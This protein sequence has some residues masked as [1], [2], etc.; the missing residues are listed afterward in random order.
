[1]TSSDATPIVPAGWY[2]DHTGEPRFRWWDGARWTEHVS[3]PTPRAVPAGAPAGNAFIWTIVLLPIVAVL[4]QF[5]VDYRAAATDPLAIYTDPGYIASALGGV[6]LYAAT[7]VLAYFDGRR[8]QRTGFDRP[9]HWAFAFIGIIVYVVGRSVI[10]YRRS[11]RGLAPLWA[12]IAITVVS[13]VIAMARVVAMVSQILTTVPGLP[14][15]A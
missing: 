13:V 12:Y 6:A 2:P 14:A 9:F 15:N 5:T 4:L 10:V 1:M 11:G 3:E 8:L 7:V